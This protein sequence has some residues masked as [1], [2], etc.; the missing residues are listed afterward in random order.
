MICKK[1]T[2]YLKSNKAKQTFANLPKYGYICETLY[3]IYTSYGQELKKQHTQ[4][5]IYRNNRTCQKT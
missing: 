3:R 1:K 5:E 4:H 2:I